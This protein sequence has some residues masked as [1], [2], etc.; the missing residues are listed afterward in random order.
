[1]KAWQK[2]ALGTSL[3]GI[4]IVCV[5]WLAFAWWLPTDEELALRLTAKAEEALGVKVSIGSV[6]WAVLPKPVI[7]VNDFRTQQALPI[8]IGK[9]SVYP[10][11]RVLLQRKLSVDHVDVDDTTVPRNSLHGLHVEPGM[12]GQYAAA[13]VP[14]QRLNFRN[15]TWISYNGIATSFDGEIDFDP[16]WRPRHAELR[17]PG[18]TPPFTLTVAREA[19]IDRWQTQIFVGGG[20]AHGYLALKT[21]EDGA[22]MHLSGQLTPR[23]IEVESAI[24]AFNRR[25]PISGKG[26]GQT[27]VSADGT[28]LG[29]LT[30]SLHTHTTFTV[31]HATVLR[32]D[33]DKAIS[34]RGKEHDGHT[35]LQELTGQLDTQNGPEGMHVTGSDIRARAGKFTAT[36]Q[37]TLYHGQ[38]EASGNLDLV[39]GALGVPFNLSGSVHKPKVTVPPGFFAGAAI[40]TVVLPGIGTVIGA[41]IGGALGKLFQGDTQ[42][43]GTKKNHP[44]QKQNATK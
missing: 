31:N 29:Q 30:R 33:L 2:W 27:V 16:H 10:N 34:T 14:L 17:R 22:T 12:A 23:D 19:D 35:P 26:S 11:L 3:A 39:E 41:R 18:I 32:F 25:S 6:H 8:V 44:V 38:I 43:P 36:G 9:L 20:T 21:A 7:T 13:G 4:A 28:S 24:S 1:M 5:A 37:G 40:G 42:Q 15:L